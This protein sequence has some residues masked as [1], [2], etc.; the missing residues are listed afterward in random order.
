MGA[1]RGA[2]EGPPVPSHAAHHRGDRG[3]FFT[4]MAKHKLTYAQAVTRFERKVLKR[5]DRIEAKEAPLRAARREAKRQRQ[6]ANRLVKITHLRKALARAAL[7]PSL[8][9]AKQLGAIAKNSDL[10]AEARVEAARLLQQW[11]FAEPADLTPDPNRAKSKVP[12]GRRR[13][14]KS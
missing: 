3:A 13:G 14:S 1:G 8:M 7:Y 2:P 4:T 10:P 9:T 5:A 11:L 12:H 6:D